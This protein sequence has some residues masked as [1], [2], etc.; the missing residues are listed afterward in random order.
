MDLVTNGSDKDVLGN[1]LHLITISLFNSPRVPP[2]LLCPIAVDL[3][4]DQ[5]PV[6][7][8][9]QQTMSVVPFI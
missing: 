4:D 2:Y 5:S 3:E 9:G 7:F 8:I 6:H 1:C